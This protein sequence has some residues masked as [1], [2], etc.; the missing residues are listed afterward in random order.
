MVGL[1]AGFVIGIAPA[2]GMEPDGDALARE[3]AQCAAF[4]Y[5]A[6]N[7]RPMEEYERLYAAGELAFNRATQILGRSTVNRLIGDASVEMTA[8]MGQDWRNFG[9]IEARLGA[10]CWELV[11]IDPD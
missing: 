10:P 7:A 4:F 2:P 3:L 9:R 6:T 5:N 8:D 1:L 11:D